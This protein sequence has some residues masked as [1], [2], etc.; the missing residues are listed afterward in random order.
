MTDSAS[1]TFHRSGLAA[2]LAACAV[3][4]AAPAAAI[5][6]ENYQKYRLD[7]RDMKATVKS[8]L[9]LRIEGVL[10]GLIVANRRL[11]A[12]GAKPLFCAPEKLQLRG[13]EV[14]R[15]LDD[16]LTGGRTAE[17]KPYPGDTLIEDVVL[18]MAR[19]RWPCSR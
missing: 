2:A 17:G 15:M 9:E 5:T 6:L 3:L 14:L 1:P 12:D 8:L 4:G 16:E 10:Q 11:V 19:R 18:V 13:S 7:S